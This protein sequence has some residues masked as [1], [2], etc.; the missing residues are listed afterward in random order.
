MISAIAN[1]TLQYQYPNSAVDLSKTA[2]KIQK[3]LRVCPL[4]ILYSSDGAAM[5][6]LI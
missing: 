5:P 4:G 6:C 3:G 2:E 1:Q